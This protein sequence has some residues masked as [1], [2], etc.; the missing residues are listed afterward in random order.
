MKL[1]K[2][3]AGT[4]SGVM[5]LSLAACTGT[6]TTSS[7]SGAG[8]NGGSSTGASEIS[9]SIASEPDTIDPALNSAVD[10]ATLIAHLF[11]GLAKW[12]QDDKGNLEIVP[13]AAKELVEGVENEDGTVTYTYTLRD[14]LKWSDGKDVTAGD[15]EFAWQ[16]AASTALAADYG[17]M[18]EVVDGYADIWD[19]DDDGNPKNPDRKSVV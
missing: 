3:M 15:F 19:V 8:G 14:G 7:N 5:L 17:Y 18:F 4:L 1:K 12:A 11:S 2:F 6:E 9:V 13:D 10:G 16:R